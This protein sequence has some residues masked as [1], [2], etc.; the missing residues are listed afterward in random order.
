MSWDYMEQR[1][2][3]V[4][5]VEL[6]DGRNT[7]IIG[8]DRE[9]NWMSTIVVSERGVDA[10]AVEA[11]GKETDNTG[12]SRVIIRSDQAA[13]SALLQA[14]QDEGEDEIDIEE[15]VELTPEKSAVAE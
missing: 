13:I 15:R 5:I 8:I 11:I 4:T 12:F 14:E 10:H 2:N 1:R 6:E 3:N 7:T 9:N